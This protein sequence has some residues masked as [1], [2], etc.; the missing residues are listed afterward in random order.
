[1]DTTNTPCICCQHPVHIKD[2]KMCYFCLFRSVWGTAKY[3]LF[4]AIIDNGNTYVTIKEAQELVNNLRKDVGI[5]PV[6]YRAVHEILHRYSE[7]YEQRKEAGS[8][9]LLLVGKRVVPGVKKPLKTYKLS[10]NL[11][12]RVD[13]Y[14]RRWRG[15]FTINTK[16][17]TGKKFVPMNLDNQRR[18]RSIML[19][20]M[21][22]E[23]GFYEFMLVNQRKDDRLLSGQHIT[24]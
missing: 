4:K 15:G 18:A 8:G 11:V 3:L 6:T 12:K 7:Y 1:M 24:S 20:M 21:R 19:R 14:T 17:K 23:I 13:T 10:A 5:K 16:N 22:G 9:Y 2:T